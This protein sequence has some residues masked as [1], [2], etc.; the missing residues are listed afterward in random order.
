MLAI[1]GMDGVPSW[2]S[3]IVCAG[4]KCGTRG[5]FCLSRTSLLFESTEGGV[6]ILGLM[7]QHAGHASPRRLVDL[8]GEPS[9]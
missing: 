5:C 3:D 1:S 6:G 4:P 9:K 7:K 2:P 8:Q